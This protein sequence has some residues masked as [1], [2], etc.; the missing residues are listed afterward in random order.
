MDGLIGGTMTRSLDMGVYPVSIGSHKIF[1][2]NR[3]NLDRGSFMPRP[4]AVIVVG[5]GEEGKWRAS[6]LARSVSQAVVA[7]AQRLAESSR[8]PKAFELAATLI[9]SGGTGVNAADA[10]RLVAQGVYNAN[11]LLRGD[12]GDGAWPLASH[13]H[14]VELYLDR[15]TEAWRALRMQAEATPGRYAIDDAVT[16]GTGPLRRQ[17]DSGYRGAEFDFISVEAKEDKDGTH[18]CRTRWTQGARAAKSVG[19]ARRASY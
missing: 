15:A 8:H 16:P 3:P 18:L 13:L 2:N 10:A 4:K 6:D 11:M 12:D 7:W 5:L 17:P 9:G 1:I 14:F 19:S